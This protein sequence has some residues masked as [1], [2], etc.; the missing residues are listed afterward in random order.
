M[1][2]SVGLRGVGQDKCCRTDIK[3][4]LGD[5]ELCYTRVALFLRMLDGVPAVKIPSYCLS[6]VYF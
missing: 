6:C 1:R 5:D 2:E 4:S 3:G